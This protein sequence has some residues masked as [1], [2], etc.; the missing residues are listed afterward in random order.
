M[1]IRNSVGHY[2][3]RKEAIRFETDI[4]KQYHKQISGLRYG[5]LIKIEM[6]NVEEQKQKEIMKAIEKSGFYNCMELV[7]RWSKDKTHL[8]VK[9]N[10]L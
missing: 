2:N 8:L 9:V 7:V 3:A 1:K 4:E 10:D 6:I 5:Q